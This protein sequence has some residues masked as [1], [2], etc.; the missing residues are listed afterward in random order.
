[1]EEKFTNSFRF[2]VELVA[3]RV[4]ADVGLVKKSLTILQPHIAVL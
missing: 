1:M 3:P 4:W 2:V